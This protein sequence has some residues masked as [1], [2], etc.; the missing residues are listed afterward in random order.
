MLESY[1]PGPWGSNCTPI[2]FARTSQRYEAK[3]QRTKVGIRVVVNCVMDACTVYI[4]HYSNVRTI[5]VSMT[6]QNE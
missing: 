5:T 3:I 4:H 6:L 1:V 2:F